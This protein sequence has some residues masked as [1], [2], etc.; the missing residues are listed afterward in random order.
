MK[1]NAHFTFFFNFWEYLL[2]FVRYTVTRLDLL[3]L[4]A[5]IS[6]D[7][8][9]IIF[10]RSLE[11]HSKLSEKKG[12]CL[13]FSSPP[14]TWILSNQ[15]PHP[16]NG[17][18][19]LSVTKIPGL[20]SNKYVFNPCFWIFFWNNPFWFNSWSCFF[21]YFLH[22]HALFKSKNHP[23]KIQNRKLVPCLGLGSQIKNF[24]FQKQLVFKLMESRERGF[25]NGFF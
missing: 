23:D 18:N 9:H 24:F 16:L 21:R 10:H 25:Q 13:E 14:P 6:F 4:V 11:L 2:K 3:F 22:K 17:E 1:N 15:N 19:P 5:F 8:S 20:F 7:I 12:F